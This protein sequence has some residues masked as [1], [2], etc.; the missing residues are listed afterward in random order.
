MCIKEKKGAIVQVGRWY[1]KWRRERK[2]E[3]RKKKNRG[4]SKQVQNMEVVLNNNSVKKKGLKRRGKGIEGE[5]GCKGEG[6][7]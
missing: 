7:Q 3:K 2:M 5:S 6:R 1:S 4:E